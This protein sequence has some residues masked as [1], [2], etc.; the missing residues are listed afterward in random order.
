MIPC[1]LDITT[2]PFCDTTILTYEIELPPSGKK[3]GFNLLGYEYFTITY[4]TDI[5]LNSPDGHQLTTQAK[6]NVW[7]IAIN[8]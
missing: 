7:I 3:V 6:Q 1:Q 8:V 5:I 2:T 4:I